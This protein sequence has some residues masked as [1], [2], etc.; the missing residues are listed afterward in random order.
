MH[1]SETLAPLERSAVSSI[2]ESPCEQPLI[3][4][5]VLVDEPASPPEIDADSSTSTSS[6]ELD[7]TPAQMRDICWEVG[8]HFLQD[9]KTDFVTFV[10]LHPRQAHFQ[11][12]I[13]EL[14]MQRLQAEHRDEW[15]GCRVTVRLYDVTDI[16]FDGR[17]AHSWFDV[18]VHNLRGVYY[19]THQ[20]SGRN[21]LAEAG[22]RLTN[23]KFLPA[24]RSNVLFAD[25]N[26]QEGKTQPVGR[27]VSGRMRRAW[28]VDSLSHAPAYERLNS[29]MAP[30][31]CRPLRIAVV[32]L[33]PDKNDGVLERIVAQF[34]EM[35]DCAEV[36]GAEPAAAAA[37]SQLP[38][39]SQVARLSVA[40]SE[41]LAESHAR[42][43]FQV[44]DC[45]EWY[46]YMV[47]AL[48]AARFGI[49]MV[50]TLHSIEKERAGDGF[51][52]GVSATV[53]QWEELALRRAERAVVASPWAAETV[54]KLYEVPHGKLSVIAN[55]DPPPG[56]RVAN[57]AEVRRSL[58][59][60]PEWS[61]IVFCN[62]IS[63]PAGADLLVEAA[64]RACREYPYSQIV[65]AGEGPLKGYLQQTIWHQGLGDRVR[66]FGHASAETF[67]SLM[68]ACDYVAIPARTGQSD[69]VAQAAIRHG[70]PVLVTHQ[71]NVRCIA[72]GQNGILAYDNIGSVEWGLKE[73]LS[74]RFKTG[75]ARFLAGRTGGAGNAPELL[76]AQYLT[77]YHEAFQ[78]Y[79]GGPNG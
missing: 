13:S 9:L 23:T 29:A 31:D 69:V 7:I 36:F 48:A 49:P 55:P 34:G 17:N 62:E 45:R 24:A 50:L 61:L 35:G 39:V 70:K 73:L 78:S 28:R 66:F 19:H 53:A 44:I 6:S 51:M 59:L 52:I 27:F 68:T 76:V 67:E 18:D 65:L 16:D 20:H 43:P 47:A 57:R 41:R 15:N 2:G 14:T 8:T 46:S 63:A 75:L 5:A 30:H 56:E 21:W 33:L 38:I 42:R 72:H 40:V 37:V 77:V 12:H 22:V 25:C 11:W 10:M 74:N 26:Y 71:A 60:H 3:D 32:K 64:A 1:T 58:G 54:S 79:K 4:E